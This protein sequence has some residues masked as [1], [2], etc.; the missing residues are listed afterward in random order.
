MWTEVENGGKNGIQKKRK[1][2]KK[3]REEKK[4]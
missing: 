2:Y 1:V 3:K 4:K